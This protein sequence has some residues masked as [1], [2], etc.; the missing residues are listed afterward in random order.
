MLGRE[1]KMYNNLSI[2]VQGAIN[3][4]ETPKCLKS[5]RKYLP[6][7]EIILSTWE[8]SDISKLE[9]LYDILVLN[10]DPGT[11]Q[12]FN[13]K[14]K[15]IYN[16]LNRQLLSTQEGLKKATK[17]Y[18]LKLRTDLILK[19][20]RFLEYFDKFPAKTENYTLF[21][22][23]IICPDLFSRYYIHVDR[24]NNVEKI[25]FHI[26]DWWFFGLK[27]DIE[28]Y[29]KDTPLVKEPEFT[30]YF[31]LKENQNK[32]SP[33]IGASFKFAPEQYF[34]YSC[35]LRNFS[36][37]RMEDASDYNDEIFEKSRECI[38]N[39]FIILEHE[40]SGI[41]LN[42]YSFSKN[43][44]CLGEAYLDLYNF[45]RYEYEYK[46]FCDKDYKITSKL[47]FNENKEFEYAKLRL[48]K[49]IFKLTDNSLP[50][51]KRLEQLFLGI[52]VSVINCAVAY[53]KKNF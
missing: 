39:N 2:I 31:S 5:L 14:G 32:K 34:G 18:V 52:P 35:F 33:Y 45:Y 37:I 51:L 9:G 21:K 47:K 25:P 42:K 10:K 27:E 40:Q 24:H 4:F 30:T 50:P 28:T 26:S 46:Y 11:Q 38:I 6:Q 13:P 49:H 29:I 20:A 19:D 23:K 1:F 44:K 7:A 16:N 3:K 48:Y 41:Y 12:F 36:D 8:G 17:K 22:K 53:S 15:I 43:E